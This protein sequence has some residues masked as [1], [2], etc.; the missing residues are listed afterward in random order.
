MQ[1]FSNIRI[2]QKDLFKLRLLGPILGVGIWSWNLIIYISH[3][4][5]GDVDAS[6]PETIHPL[7]AIGLLLLLFLYL[8]LETLF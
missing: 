7:R 6:E 1:W 4:F 2:T 3:K 8:L 5:P